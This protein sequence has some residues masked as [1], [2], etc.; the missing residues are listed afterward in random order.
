MSSTAFRIDELSGDS[1]DS[2]FGDFHAD[3]SISKTV[4]ANSNN[5]GALKFTFVSNL[6]S[7]SR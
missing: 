4:K 2:W 1:I 5:S 7:S 3:N 6:E